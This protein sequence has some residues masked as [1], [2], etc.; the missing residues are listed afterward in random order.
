MAELMNLIPLDT[1][2]AH[3]NDCSKRMWDN[4]SGRA[5]MYRDGGASHGG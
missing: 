3:S 4:V 1:L 5:R 2:H